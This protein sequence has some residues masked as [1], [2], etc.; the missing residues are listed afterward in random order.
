MKDIQEKEDFHLTDS[1]SQEISAD[2]EKLL[3]E[4]GLFGA[5]RRQFLGHSIAGG[6]GIFALQLLAKEKAIAALETSPEAV[7]AQNAG[8]EN[9]V[10][11]SLK[12]NGATLAVPRKL[13]PSVLTPVF[14][15]SFQVSVSGAA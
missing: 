7:F 15:P 13:E 10:R 1:D 6:L 2:E 4:L 9:A 8:L 11:V 14:P 3:D 12:I 5:A